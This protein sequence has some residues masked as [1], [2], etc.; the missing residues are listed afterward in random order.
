MVAGTKVTILHKLFV[1]IVSS[2]TKVV[3]SFGYNLLLTPPNLTTVCT[4]V[5]EV[6]AHSTQV[7]GQGKHILHR[8][9]REKWSD[10][11][12][13]LLWCQER[14]GAGLLVPWGTLFA[15][16]PTSFGYQRSHADARLAKKV[17]CGRVTHS[18]LPMFEAF[19]I[20]IWVCYDGNTTVDFKLNRYIPSQKAIADAIKAQQLGQMHAD[21]V[22][23]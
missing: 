18:Y 13:K 22:W 2:P 16:A 9:I 6:V 12:Q 5:V 14:L 8:D 19:S 3:K 7:D 1:T 23:G 15:H 10:L 21:S 4:V 11:E 17:A 20:P